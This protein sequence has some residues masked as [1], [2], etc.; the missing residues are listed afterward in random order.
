MRRIWIIPLALTLIA[1]PRL[2]TAAVAISASAADPATA[3]SDQYNLVDT[4]TI[5]GGTTPGGGTYNSQSYSDNAGPPGQTFT[6][7]NSAPGYRLTSVSF[8]GTGDAG[9]GSLGGEWGIRVSSISGT[10]LSAIGTTTDIPSPASAANTD[11]LTWTFS[12]GD[13]LTL[14]PGA[15]YAV[16]VY[17]ESGWWGIGGALD[18]AYA[19]GTAFNSA[20]AARGFAD[21][22]LG[23]LA[24]HGY[25]R[26]FHIGLTPVPEPAAGLLA[27]GGLA[28]LLA[29]RR[30]RR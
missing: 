27:I 29:A 26:T 18:G 1:A 30:R 6:T 14:S 12:G 10:S 5:P 24:N 28:P 13:V 3:A 8:K 11:W 16:D 19:G 25:D 17:S 4:E 23:T 20:G 15:Q 22:T 7:T 2:S 9:G 21:A